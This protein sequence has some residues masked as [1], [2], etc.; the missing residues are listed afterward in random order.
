MRTP[1]IAAALAAAEGHL[2]AA[3]A[4]HPLTPVTG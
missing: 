4:I 3:P 1:H 2:A